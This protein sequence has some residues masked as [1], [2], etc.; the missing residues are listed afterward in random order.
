M[1]LDIPT[2]TDNINSQSVRRWDIWA[3]YSTFSLWC[4]PEP[5][6]ASTLCSLPA[7]PRAPPLASTAMVAPDTPANSK[8]N[9]P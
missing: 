2:Q 1:D 4:G 7:G 3:V 8:A 6:S 5:P 9:V